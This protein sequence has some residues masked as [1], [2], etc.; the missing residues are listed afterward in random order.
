MS[1]YYLFSDFHMEKGF[2]TEVVS[3]L[4][5]DIKDNNKIVFI[6]SS[7][8]H[9]SN[10]DKYA[11][12]Y[13]EWFSN[14]GIKFKLSTVIDNRMRKGEMIENIKDA[15]VIFLMGGQTLTQF[16]FLKENDLDKALRICEGCILGLSAGAINMAKI[17]INTEKSGQDRAVIYEGLNLVD[18][19][20]EPHFN[21]KGSGIEYDKLLEASEKYDIYAMC[22][23]SAI[24]CRGKEQFFYGEIYF[25]SKGK[26]EK[27]N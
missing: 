9:N 7:P 14:I 27:V 21:P 12:R 25:I 24:V 23:N 15:S 17:S 8:E 26:L 5:I 19:S 20:I 16:K 3:N 18:V 11:Q 4:L 22:D 10:T 6:A 13:L 1:V 2:T